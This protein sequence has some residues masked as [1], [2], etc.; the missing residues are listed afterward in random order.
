MA[1]GRLYF[2]IVSV[3][4]CMFYCASHYEEWPNRGWQSHKGWG[5]REQRKE[6]DKRRAKEEAE[7]KKAR[8]NARRNEEVVDGQ[9]FFVARD[10][11]DGGRKR[12]R[13]RATVP[14]RADRRRDGESGSH[15]GRNG[16][17]KPSAADK[18]FDETKEIK[19]TQR[20]R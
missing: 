5:N 1:I 14:G 6:E 9:T 17:G 4:L 15:G 18:Y 3:A 13:D 8:E 19:P 2:Y 10:V 20:W 7:L 12:K 11:G 16:G